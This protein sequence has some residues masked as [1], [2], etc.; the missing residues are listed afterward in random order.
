MISYRYIK[1]V[2][3]DFVFYSD[4]KSSIPQRN[5][6]ILNIEQYNQLSITF[7]QSTITF[8]FQIETIFILYFNFNIICN[9][10]VIL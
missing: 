6:K 4:I 9:Y 7:K 3:D 1:G 8:V 2:S 5:I 10:T